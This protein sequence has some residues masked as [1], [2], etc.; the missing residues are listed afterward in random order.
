MSRT[1]IDVKRMQNNAEQAAALLKSLAH[2]SRL[3]VL[4]ALV[5]RE[6][7]AGELEDLTGLSQ[8]AVSQHLAR[9]RHSGLVKTRRNGQWISYSLSSPEVRQV[10][11]TLHAL[12]CPEDF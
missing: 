7:T 8:S 2:P 10:L 4:C 9:L 11:E 3:L 6:H 5:N 1:T 12:Y